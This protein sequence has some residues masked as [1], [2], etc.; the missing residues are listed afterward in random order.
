MSSVDRIIGQGAP[1]RSQ[2]QDA[3]AP[4][5]LVINP[6][7][8]LGK[9]LRKW[10]QHYSELTPRG[11]KPGNPYEFRPY[12]KMLY[13]AVARK[14]K[15]ECLVGVPEVW[16]YEKAEMF[17]RAVQET[18]AFNKSNQKIVRDE[19]E[20]AVATGQGWAESPAAAIAAYE[21]RQIAIGNAAAEANFAASRMSEKAQRELTAANEQTDAH[22]VDV[23]K[24]RKAVTGAGVIEG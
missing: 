21:Q 17:E 6:H 2:L 14:G 3:E 18:E 12:P 24:G 16:G 22:V 13:R 11:T 19:L 4:G 1:D 9:E 5:G 7:S 10:E 23:K 20:E 15:P 8:E